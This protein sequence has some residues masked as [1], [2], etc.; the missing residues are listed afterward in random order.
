[1]PCGDWST[2]DQTLSAVVP[3][4]C[5]PMWQKAEQEKNRFFPISFRFFF[6]FNFWQFLDVCSVLWTYSSYY[7][8]VKQTNKQTGQNIVPGQ[9][10]LLCCVHTHWGRRTREPFLRSQ[11][12]WKFESKLL[13]W[14]RWA[15]LTGKGACCSIW[16]PVWSWDPHGKKGD[17]VTKWYALI[18]TKVPQHINISQ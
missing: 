7:P 5:F 12:I 4:D 10:H 18:V 16:E 11:A 15:G 1:M 13:K 3:G 9:L 8:L 2:Q 6:K 14:G 17:L